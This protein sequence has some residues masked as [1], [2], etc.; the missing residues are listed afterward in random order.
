MRTALLWTIAILVGAL[1]LWGIAHVLISPVHPDQEPPSG[2][3][4]APCWAC[5]LVSESAE[6][7]AP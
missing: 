3:F 5:H 4:Q 2:H 1:V 7:T 6:L